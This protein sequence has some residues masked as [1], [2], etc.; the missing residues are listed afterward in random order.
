VPRSLTGAE[1]IAQDYDLVMRVAELCNTLSSAIVQLNCRLGEKI[2]ITHGLCRRQIKKSLS[3][4][5]K[6]FTF[7]EDVREAW[8]GA[9]LLLPGFVES[10]LAGSNCTK[11]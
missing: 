11:G 7:S 4:T 5:R 3:L 6:G 10:S 9:Y 2:C 1:S 8:D